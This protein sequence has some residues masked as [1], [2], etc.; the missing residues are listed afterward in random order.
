MSG[1]SLILQ[2]LCVLEIK[3]WRMWVTTYTI[4]YTSLILQV[5]RVLEIKFWRMRGAQKK[6]TT[7]ITHTTATTTTTLAYIYCSYVVTGYAIYP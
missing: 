3:I 1:T 5:L 7:T 4:T 2:V 6:T